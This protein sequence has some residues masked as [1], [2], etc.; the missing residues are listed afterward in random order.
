MKSVLIFASFYRIIAPIL[1]L[2]LSPLLIIINWTLISLHKVPP[3]NSRGKVIV[4]TG[5]S[6]GIGAETAKRYA[7]QGA[8]LILIAR[9]KPELKAVAESCQ[10]LG[11]QLVRIHSLDVTNEEA[12]KTAIQETGNEFGCIDLVLWNAGN[13]MVEKIRDCNDASIFRRLTELNYLS[14]VAGTVYALPYL[15]KSA[16]GKVGVVSSICGITAAPSSSGYCG[17]KFGLKGFFDCLRIEEPTLD[18]SMIYPGMVTTDIFD[19][20]EGSSPNK[21]TPKN[22]LSQVMTPTEAADLIVH[23]I[24][25]GFRDE[26]FTLEG[27]VLWYLKDFYSVVVNALTTFGY[28]AALTKKS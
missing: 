25:K 22:T 15:K 21:V 28:E 16:R 27:N 18:V 13:G 23:A 6:S 20:V 10:H 2:I 19:K 5:A 3:F 17:T 26:V 11:A 8:K 24:D 4:I 7:Q 9:R 14:V 12:L 1:F